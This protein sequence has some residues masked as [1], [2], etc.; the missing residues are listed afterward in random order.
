[1]SSTALAISLWVTA[2]LDGT[3]HGEPKMICKE[4]HVRTFAGERAVDQCAAARK[5]AVDEWLAELAQFRLYP[6]IPAVRCGPAGV[7]ETDGDDA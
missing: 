2:C 7:G 4:F 5:T 6:H 3:L 1:M